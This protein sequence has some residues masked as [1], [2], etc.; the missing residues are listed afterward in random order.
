MDCCPGGRVYACRGPRS[1]PS[2]CSGCLYFCIS[3]VPE[4]VLRVSFDAIATAV[5]WAT[6]LGTCRLYARCRPHFSRPHF[7]QHVLVLGRR[8]SCWGNGRFWAA[9]RG[10]T[11]QESISILR[12]GR[13]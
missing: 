8:R 2:S 3:I 4:I 9:R 11:W 13:Q 1:S 12:K 6:W 10:A 5:P 7:V